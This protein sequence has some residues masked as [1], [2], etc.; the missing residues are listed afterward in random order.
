MSVRTKQPPTTIA[1][2]F[3]LDD[4]AEAFMLGVVHRFHSGAPR[5]YTLLDIRRTV[6]HVSGSP[7]RVIHTLTRFQPR[8]S[9]PARSWEWITFDID[10]VAIHFQTFEGIE[11]ARAAFTAATA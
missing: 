2:K 6:S 9:K 11:A 8:K 5:L 10:D 3:N 7:R 4:P 1:A